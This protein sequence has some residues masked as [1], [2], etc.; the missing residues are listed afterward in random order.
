MSLTGLR[1]ILLAG[2]ALVLDSWGATMTEARERPG[3]S[4]ERRAG[5][6]VEA[7]LAADRAYATQAQAQAQGL[8][9]LLA[10]F[11]EAVVMPSPRGMLRGKAAVAGLLQRSS[12]RGAGELIWA[13]IRAGVSADGSHGFT[14]GYLDT[15][16]PGSPPRAAKYLSY[17]RKSDGLWKVIAYKQA[18]CPDGERTGTLAPSRPHPPRHGGDAAAERRTL[19]AREQAFSD[20]A[21]SLGLGQAFARFGHVD[22]VNMGRTAGFTIGAEAIG[23]ELGAGGAPTLAWSADDA[24]VAPSGDLG[25]TWGHIRLVDAPENGRVIPFFTIWRRDGAD[26]EWRYVAE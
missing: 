24:L 21:G 12:G 20:A 13:P 19:I 5:A 7:L 18:P 15:G 25:L 3:A 4:P 10:M 2:S 8:A 14:F 11:D 22:A 9:G 23:R 17:W 26:A 16:K 1:R 6:S